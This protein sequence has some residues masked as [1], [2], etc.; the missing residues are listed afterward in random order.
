MFAV[1][2][3]IYSLITHVKPV[4]SSN[5]TTVLSVLVPTPF[6][7]FEIVSFFLGMLQLFNVAYVF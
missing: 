5:S 2:I 4:T 3:I 1:I 7:F 6:C